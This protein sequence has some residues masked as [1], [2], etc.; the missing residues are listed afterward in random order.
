MQAL[1]TE[2]E[3]TQIN[4]SSWYL[5][6]SYICQKLFVN[7][8]NLLFIFIFSPVSTE[9]V[10]LVYILIDESDTRSYRRSQP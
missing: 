9:I 1:D 5:Q 2:K 7:N 3:W 4:S 8:T 10:Y 6:S